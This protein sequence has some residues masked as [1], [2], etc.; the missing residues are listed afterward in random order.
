VLLLFKKGASRAIQSPHDG[1]GELHI[2]LAFPQRIDHWESWL[3]TK[4][5]QSK[6]SATGLGGC[7]ST[8]R[9]RPSLVELATPALVRLLNLSLSLG[10]GARVP[11]LGLRWLFVL[12]QGRFNRAQESKRNR[13]QP[14][15]VSLFS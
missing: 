1:D 2:A 6:K 9:P 3:Q 8:S 14:L 10:L 11:T 4:E 7:S 13:L 12:P 15:R 5:L